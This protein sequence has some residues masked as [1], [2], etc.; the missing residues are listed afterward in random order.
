MIRITANIAIDE[1]E[2]RERYIRSPG[3]GGQNVNKV[4]SCVQLRFDAARSK[5][6]TEAVKRRLKPLAGRR[7]TAKGVI[8]I[9][10]RRFRARERN[11]EDALA[12]LVALIKK[13]AVA[14]KHRRPTRPTKGSVRRGSEAKRRRARLKQTRQKVLGE[15]G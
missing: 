2:L 8:V 1:N 4:A 9:E 11:R 3:P 14:P 6:L 7:M 15:E 5:A 12:R 10:A 13:A